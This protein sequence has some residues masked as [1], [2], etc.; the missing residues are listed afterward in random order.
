M[1]VAKG[2]R[3]I[4]PL[5]PGILWGNPRLPFFPHGFQRGI[6]RR[7]LAL[8]D[9]GGANRGRNGGNQGYDPG[10]GRFSMQII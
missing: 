2:W 8:G 4:R 1:D 5:L 10:F 7:D 3:I 6:G 9:G